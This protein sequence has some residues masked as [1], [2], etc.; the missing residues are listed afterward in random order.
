MACNF[1]DWLRAE[2]TW[3]VLFVVGFISVLA[4]GASCQTSFGSIAV[5]Q[6][7]D[8][9][10][11]VAADSKNLSAKGVSLR[12]C[13][14]HALDPQLVFANTGYGS[15]EGVRGKWDAIALARQHYNQFAKAPRHELIPAVAEAYGAD[16]A[17]KLS[18]D[19]SAHSEEG[20][21]QT[22]VTALFAG[23]DENRERVVIEVNV[24]QMRR[25]GSAV[26]YSTKRLPA[27]DAVYAEV[28]GETSIA[29][30]FAAGR[31]LRAQAWRNGLNFQVQGL[32]VKD[33]LIVGAEKIVEL[34]ARY[35]PSLVGGAVDT[36]LL[37]RKTGVVWIHRK[38]ECASRRG[39]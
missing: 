15:Y 36:V 33:R 22:L 4:N 7:A 29:E 28:V 23:F 30:E 11:V 24:H 39:E 9:Y 10:L 6:S 38:P 34:T 12:K 32:G 37:S 18:P 1:A 31:T 8:D 21:P 5:L 17:A 27:S 25:N 35:Q 2:L 13:K 16:V 14:I 3:K 20:W 19:V 26:G